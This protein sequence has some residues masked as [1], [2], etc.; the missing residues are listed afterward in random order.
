[1]RYYGVVKT[2]HDL[3]LLGEFDSPQ[4]A[5]TE[6]NLDEMLVIA[7]ERQVLSWRDA[8]QRSKSSKTVF[9]LNLN[10]GRVGPLGRF[11]SQDD[12]LGYLAANHEDADHVLLDPVTV[13]GWRM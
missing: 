2:N 1:M 6:K 11:K 13:R 12:A 3:M 8:I 10:E 4:A 9:S 7:D 5:N